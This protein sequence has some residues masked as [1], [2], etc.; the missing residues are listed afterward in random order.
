[1]KDRHYATNLISLS[2]LEA[3]LSEVERTS[4]LKWN[5]LSL[6]LSEVPHV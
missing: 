5:V 6:S 3:A 1:M 2:S 4:F